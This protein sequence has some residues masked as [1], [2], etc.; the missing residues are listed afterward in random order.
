MFLVISV[1]EVPP[2]VHVPQLAGLVVLRPREE[3]AGCLPIVAVLRRGTESC[4]LAF[5]PWWEG[6]DMF[7]DSLI[8]QISNLIREKDFTG[9][10]L[11]S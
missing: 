10:K 1:V 8:V 9:L 5:R 4:A 6:L 7:L 2:E 3:V 11:A